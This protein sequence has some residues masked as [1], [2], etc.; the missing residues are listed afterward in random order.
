[1]S[2]TLCLINYEKP[3]TMIQITRRFFLNHDILACWSTLFA[4]LFAW[5]GIKF[6]D[7]YIFQCIENMVEKMFWP[8][9]IKRNT[10]STYIKRFFSHSG[11]QL[12]STLTLW[13]AYPL[14]NTWWLFPAWNVFYFLKEDR[15]YMS[16]WIMLRRIFITDSFSNFYIKHTKFYTNSLF[17]SDIFTL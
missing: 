8:M 14:P 11:D 10:C 15:R 6:I 9:T 17:P 3:N 7:L 2:S 1:M 5:K 12:L 16:M 13:T 4:V